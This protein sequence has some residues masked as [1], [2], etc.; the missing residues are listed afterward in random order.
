MLHISHCGNTGVIHMQQ[1]RVEY[2]CST[3]VI[4]L[5]IPHMYYRC[6]TNDH[7]INTLTK[8]E[9]LLEIQCI[10]MKVSSYGK[11]YGKTSPL[12]TFI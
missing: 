3:R 10:T 1:I 5:K 9:E 7:I 11:T 8:C 12:K 2:N 6:G 4:H